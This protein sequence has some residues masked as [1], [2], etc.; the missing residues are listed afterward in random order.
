MRGLSISENALNFTAV[1]LHYTADAERDSDHPDETIR[2]KAAIWLQLQ[3][4]LWPDPNDW[5]RE[6]EI[7][8]FVA[9]G[10]RVFP[11]FTEETHGSDA[12]YNRRRVMYRGWDFGWHTPC[13]LMAQVDG[14]D[15]LVVLREIVGSQQTTRDFAQHVIDRCAEWFPQHAAGFE[16]L[17]DP[18]GQ[19][20]QTI[21]SEKSERRDI[22]V[23][24]GLGIF[25]RYEHGWS[26]KDGRALVHQLLRI[27]T[28]RTPSLYVNVVNCSVLVR[29]FLGGYCYPETRDGQIHEEPD[30]KLHPWS[31]V[32]AALRYL[33]TGLHGKLGLRRLSYLPSAQVAPQVIDWHGYGI[34]TRS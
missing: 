2:N 27:R 5:A 26:R 6:M 17:C 34:P 10:R 31:D 11:Q 16:D 1:R 13:C 4:S 9:E 25:P 29:A 18:A 30:D 14:K 12:P 3:R 21:E 24:N 28:D 22:E 20:V 33:V 15:R 19:Q 23:L 8:F 7:N 32:M